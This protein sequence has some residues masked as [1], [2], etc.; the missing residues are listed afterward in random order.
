[1]PLGALPGGHTREPTMI[2]DDLKSLARDTKL[3]FRRAARRAVGA[4]PSLWVDIVDGDA[5]PTLQGE[6]G[7]YCRQ[8][9]DA[10]GKPVG[11]NDYGYERSTRRVVVGRDW[12]P[13]VAASVERA[14]KRDAA[15]K[16]VVAKVEAE[17][18]ASLAASPEPVKTGAYRARI[19]A[20]RDDAAAHGEASMVAD[21]NR[22]LASLTR[23]AGTDSG[24]AAELARV[25]DALNDSAASQ[26]DRSDERAERIGEA[27][28]VVLAAARLWQLR[29][30]RP[31]TEPE[32]ELAKLWDAVEAFGEI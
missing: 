11:V 10:E 27:T 26:L 4:S 18:N 7:G 12:K 22:V 32:P 24:V 31:E 14:P 30:P 13:T 5:A 2:K 23:G 19:I 8:Q 20:L 1:M 3:A 15:A 28:E 29:Y 17:I 21:C 25:V 6:E 16:A 9:Y